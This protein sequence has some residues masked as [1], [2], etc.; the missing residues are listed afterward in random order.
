M[1]LQVYYY[2]VLK[3][4]VLCTYICTYQVSTLSFIIVSVVD[5][6]V[7]VRNG[8]SIIQWYACREDFFIPKQVPSHTHGRA[9]CLNI[10]LFEAPCD[11]LLLGR[12]PDIYSIKCPLLAIGNAGYFSCFWRHSYIIVIPREILT[13]DS[14]SSW[15]AYFEFGVGLGLTRCATF[16]KFQ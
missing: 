9:G 15:H 6:E 4:V 14:E 13:K 12:P 1:M 7:Q 10:F 5:L 2:A 16:K 11:P 8:G 3:Y